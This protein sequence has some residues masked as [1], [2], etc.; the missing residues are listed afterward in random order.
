MRPRAAAWLL[1]L[2][3]CVA[4]GCG[5]NELESPTAAKLRALSNF[6]LDYAVSA[7]DSRGPGTAEALKKHILGKPDFVLSTS[8]VDRASIDSLF[9][10]DRDGEP[11]VILTGT[12]ITKIS[13]VSGVVV[14]H[15]KS[16]KNGKR[17]VVLSNTKVELADDSRLQELMAVK[18]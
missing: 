13:G 5:P 10:S 7:K 11:F 18:Q 9:I 15:E 3:L 2:G 12:V 14:A 4:T 17:L 8:D 6:Y 16:G 1:L